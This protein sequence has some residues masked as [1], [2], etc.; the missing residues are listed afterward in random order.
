MDTLISAMAL[1]Q[2]QQQQQQQQQHTT[3]LIHIDHDTMRKDSVSLPQ[4]DMTHL[5][6]LRPLSPQ[7]QPKS[8]LIQPQYPQMPQNVQPEF[9]SQTQPMSAQ[10]PP[11][12]TATT[13]P[14]SFYMQPPP[15]FTQPYP[16]PTFT[17]ST[18]HPYA[19]PQHLVQQPPASSPPAGVPAAVPP[20]PK[21][22]P[23]RK[24]TDDAPANKR[25]AQNRLAQKTHR[26]RKAAYT[27]GLEAQVAQLSALLASSRQ[28]VTGLVVHVDQLR[29]ENRS[30]KE[31]SCFRSCAK[32]LFTSDGKL[33]NGAEE[34]CLQC[35]SVL[36]QKV[37]PPTPVQSQAQST[38]EQQQ[39]TYYGQQQQHM[40]ASFP[41]SN[42]LSPTASQ[43]SE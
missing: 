25:I 24:P 1:H 41:Q 37:E 5:A 26:E 31:S 17:S 21:N 12:S 28:E 13:N 39:A 22:K 4:T 36:A 16:Q 30:L 15:Q 6:P 42:N 33:K 2:Q 43:Q 40:Q 10:L 34:P 38:Q 19:V 27:Q 29:N 9:Y 18:Y 7:I 3:R 14:S 32:T 20:K 11:L 23:G 8:E 35:K